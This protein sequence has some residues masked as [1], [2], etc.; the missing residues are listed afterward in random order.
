MPNPVKDTQ[1][2]YIALA[3]VLLLLAFVAVLVV[4][5]YLLNKKT[6]QLPPAE[7]QP[8]PAEIPVAPG[9]AGQ[10]K[11]H[12]VETKTAA[13]LMAIIADQLGKPLNELRFISIREVENQ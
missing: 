1:P 13:M 12:T 6:A 9:T 2:D 4:R 5:K 11:L 3:M 7:V 8:E 10:I